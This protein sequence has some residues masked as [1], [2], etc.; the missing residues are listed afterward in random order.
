[1]GQEDGHVDKK[2]KHREREQPGEAEPGMILPR[3]QLKR[4]ACRHE[5]GRNEQYPQLVS[6]QKRV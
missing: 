6:M 3:A 4:G 1:M 2:A 5:H